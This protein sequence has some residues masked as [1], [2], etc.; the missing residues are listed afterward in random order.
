MLG[1]TPGKR[2][3]FSQDFLA[4]AGSVPLAIAAYAQAVRTGEFPGPE[5]SFE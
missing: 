5:H 4:Q 3:R 1:I 2:P